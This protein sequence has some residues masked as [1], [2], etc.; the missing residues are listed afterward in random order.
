MIYIDNLRLSEVW[1]PGNSRFLLSQLNV[2]DE[3]SFE[4]F[5]MTFTSHN[6]II[7]HVQLDGIIWL[8]GLY[9]NCVT[10]K[11]LA[12]SLLSGNWDRME[13]YT[14]M[15]PQETQEGAFYRAALALHQNHFQQAQAVRNNTIPLMLI[16]T[17]R[18]RADIS[19]NIFVLL[20]CIQMFSV[21]EKSEIKSVVFYSR[22]FSFTHLVVSV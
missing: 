20:S 12:L 8:P 11:W 4:L 9:L 14:C 3:L 5:W 13:E 22:A 2:D 18:E 17:L 7:S 6:I 19:F 1:T 10:I 21:Y 16:H 15:I